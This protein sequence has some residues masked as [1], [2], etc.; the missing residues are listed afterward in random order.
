MKASKHGALRGFNAAQGDL[1][2]LILGIYTQH[3]RWEMENWLAR[4][5]LECSACRH[6]NFT[7]QRVICGAAE[8]G[9]IDI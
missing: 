8:L 1:E 5:D 3:G 9:K 7:M 6:P 2:T 4:H